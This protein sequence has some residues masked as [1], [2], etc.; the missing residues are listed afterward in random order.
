VLLRVTTADNIST[1][2]RTSEKSTAADRV[3]V[4]ALLDPVN[5]SPDVKVPEGIVI[6]KVVELGLL[7]ICAVAELD[8]PVMVSP[9]V[10]D[11]EAPTVIVS[12]P[13]G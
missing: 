1:V 8:P 4:A 7:V 11:V 6:A 9:T 3:V 5:V 2:L 12:V 13:Q 10:N